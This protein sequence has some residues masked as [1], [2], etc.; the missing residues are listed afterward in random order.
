MC[1]G[2]VVSKHPSVRL[3]ITGKHFIPVGVA[4]DP[5]S[6]LETPG[7]TGRDVIEEDLVHARARAYDLGEI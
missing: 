6:V 2:H 1:E 4:V 7:G 3:F 5:E